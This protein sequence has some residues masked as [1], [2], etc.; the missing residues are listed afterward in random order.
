MNTTLTR[1]IVELLVV[2]AA[3]GLLLELSNSHWWAIILI[4]AATIA[5]LRIRRQ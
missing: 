5:W 4:G 2:L 3:L 1:I